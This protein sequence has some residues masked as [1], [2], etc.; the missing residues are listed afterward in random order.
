MVGNVII[1]FNRNN[2]QGNIKVYKTFK[3]KIVYNYI[4]FAMKPSIK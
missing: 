2:Q 3:G 1:I 4:N